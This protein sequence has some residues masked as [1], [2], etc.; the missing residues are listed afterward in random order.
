MCIN[1]V[2][3]L[4]SGLTLI[5]LI[6]YVKYIVHVYLQS[7]TTKYDFKIDWL[8]SVYSHFYMYRM[9]RFKTIKLVLFLWSVCTH[10]GELWSYLEWN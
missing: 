8:L 1:V 9:T 10:V 2:A 6:T 5:F 7:R 4:M 3:F